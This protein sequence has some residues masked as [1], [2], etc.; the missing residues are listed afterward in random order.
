[1][2]SILWR[3]RDGSVVEPGRLYRT[4]RGWV[5]PEP[6]ACP[7]GHR[8]GPGRV[9]VGKIACAAVG[10]HRTHACRTCDAV[11]MWPPLTDACDHRVFDERRDQ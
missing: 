3:L 7:N 1:M 2:R 6:A 5:E 4:R 8:L 11:I 10:L 9:L